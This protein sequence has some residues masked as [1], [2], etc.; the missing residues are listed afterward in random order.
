[1]TAHEVEIRFRRIRVG[2]DVSRQSLVALEAAADLARTLE[3]EIEGIFIED[4]ELLQ[5]ASRPGAA[6]IAYPSGVRTELTFPGMECHLRAL[7]REARERLQA[8]AERQR[9]RWTFH[10]ARGK[11]SDELLARGLEDDLLILGAR[12]RLSRTFGRIGSTVKD[13]VA[14]ARGP[15]LLVRGAAPRLGSCL[16]SFFDGSVCA[17]KALRIASSLS[18]KLSVVIVPDG[19]TEETRD[20]D[21]VERRASE[22]LRELGREDVRPVRG[23]MSGNKIVLPP[24]HPRDGAIVF[25]LDLACLAR[26]DLLEMIEESDLPVLLVPGGKVR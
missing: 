24:G 3:A 11:V 13:A 22:L 15:V 9:L 20:S 16:I 14:L 2:I 17:E 4:I 10:V 26:Q 8:E 23:R 7:A 12:G 21:A 1:M 5:A 19:G 18:R 6:E 25:P